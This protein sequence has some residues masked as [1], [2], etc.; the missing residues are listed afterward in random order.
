MDGKDDIQIKT[1]ENFVINNLTKFKMQLIDTSDSFVLLFENPIVEELNR[2]KRIKYQFTD[3]N[4]SSE[5]R[6][7]SNLDNEYNTTNDITFINST[8]EGTNQVLYFVGIP[9]GIPTSR[10]RDIQI[11][12]YEGESDIYPLGTYPN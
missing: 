8:V 7:L 11:K 3:I 1:F 9:I 6:E 12:L 2:I 10:I 4:G 5:I